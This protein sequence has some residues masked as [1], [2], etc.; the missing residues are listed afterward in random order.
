[1]WFFAELTEYFQSRKAHIVGKLNDQSFLQI[2]KPG[3]QREFL[4]GL[5]AIVEK[6]IPFYNSSLHSLLQSELH[7]SKRRLI[8]IVSDFL[9]YGEAEKKL[10]AQLREK[11]EVRLVQLPTRSGKISEAL[12]LTPFNQ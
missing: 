9:A 6:T 10:I 1:M 2:E 12:L 7:T 8:I 11:H 5:I 3:Y 4:E